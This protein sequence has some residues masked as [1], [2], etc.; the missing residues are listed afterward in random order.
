[1][2]MIILFS[3]MFVYGMEKIKHGRVTYSKSSKGDAESYLMVRH[4]GDP[5]CKI[6]AGRYKNR[7][8][9]WRYYGQ[10]ERFKE[11]VRNYEEKEAE[12]QFNFLCVEY[13]VQEKQQAQDTE[14]PNGAQDV[15][16]NKNESGGRE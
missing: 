13:K 9:R 2:F 3:T 5:T 11:C 16:M 1:M 10:W 15:A 12:R 6:S 14:S 8:D 7:G 4:G